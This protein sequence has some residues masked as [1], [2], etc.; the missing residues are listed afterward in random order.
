LIA[1]LAGCASIGLM[2]L[3]HRQPQKTGAVHE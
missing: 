2:T 1:I 3:L